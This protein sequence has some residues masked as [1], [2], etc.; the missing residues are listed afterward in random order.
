MCNGVIPVDRL[1]DVMKPIEII[2]IDRIREIPSNT[3]TTSNYLYPRCTRTKDGN[4]PRANLF[5]H[6]APLVGTRCKETDRT[7]FALVAR[8][9]DYI[10]GKLLFC[11]GPEGYEG[12]LGASRAGEDAMMGYG[13]GAIEP[14]PKNDAKDEA[15]T[16]DDPLAAALWTT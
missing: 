5:A 6:T 13:A 11:V 4:R 2:A 1:T 14:M 3:C 10:N 12:P 8:L 15:E 16:D 9:K 7:K